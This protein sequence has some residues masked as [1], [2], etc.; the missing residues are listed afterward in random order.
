MN[1]EHADARFNPDRTQVESGRRQY[2]NKKE[3][4]LIA[5]VI[6]GV[7]SVCEPP[8]RPFTINL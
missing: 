3:K 1:D 8:T 5:A 2:I 7:A 4:A 6:G